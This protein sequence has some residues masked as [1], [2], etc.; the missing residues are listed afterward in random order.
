MSPLSFNLLM[1]HLLRMLVR[2]M[3]LLVVCTIEKVLWLATS[4]FFLRIIIIQNQILGD[5]VL[6]LVVGASRRKL[7]NQLIASL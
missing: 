3:I 4:E 6:L 7:D 5:F 2:I 1:N